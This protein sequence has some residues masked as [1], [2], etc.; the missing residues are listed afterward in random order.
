MNE[1][2]NGAAQRKTRMNRVGVTDCPRS[3]DAEQALASIH[4]PGCTERRP[5]LQPRGPCLT[6]PVTRAKVVNHAAARPNWLLFLLC[7]AFPLWVWLLLH[8]PGY[9]L[10]GLIL[11]GLGWLTWQSGIVAEIASKQAQKENRQ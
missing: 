4:G 6:V 11:Y 8:Y 3:D 9:L 5:T 2:D 7:L 1:R 10:V